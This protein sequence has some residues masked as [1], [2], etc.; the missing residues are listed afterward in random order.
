MFIHPWVYSAMNAASVRQNLLA[1]NIAN[2]ETP[3]YQRVDLRFAEQLRLQLQRAEERPVLTG[4]RTHPLHMEIGLPSAEA[5]R[6]PLPYQ[7]VREQRFTESNAQNNV[8]L[9]Y[10]MASMTQ[11]A[12]WYQ[13]LTQQANHQLQQLRRAVEGR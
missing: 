6:E 3:Y 4:R 13:A 11:N 10:E 7:V 5:I 9:E 1:H 2:A 8:D 12:L